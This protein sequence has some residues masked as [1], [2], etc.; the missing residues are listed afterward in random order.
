VHLLDVQAEPWLTGMADLTVQPVAHPDNPPP[1]KLDTTCP[2]RS[3]HTVVQSGV[4]IAE[5][6]EWHAYCW[7]RHVSA[8]MAVKPPRRGP[9]KPR[10]GTQT[11]SGPTGTGNFTWR[12]T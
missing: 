5:G 1:C 7:V 8:H 9:Q 6:C 12:P 11:G 3:T 2:N 10:S 4:A